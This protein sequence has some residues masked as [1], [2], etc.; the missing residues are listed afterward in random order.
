MT[1]VVIVGGG[2]VGL[3]TALCLRRE[4]L[5]V[6]VVDA[7]RPPLD[8]ACGEGLMPDGVARLARL[9]VSLEGVRSRPFRG[10]R[11]VDGDLAVEADFP[12]SPGRGVRRTVLHEALAV[13]AEEAG[14]EL[15]WGTRVTGLTDAGVTTEEGEVP[16]RWVVGADGLL[17]RVR[18]WAGLDSGERRRLGD[19]ARPPRDRR[20]FGV[21]R[22]YR[23]AP[24][25][26]RVE[27][28]WGD[29]CEA[30]V[31]PVAAD[32]VGVA[33]LWSGGPSDFDGLL[34][35]FPALGARL[36]GAEP[37]SRDRGAG[38]LDQRVRGLVRGRVVLVGDAA[39]YRDA[40][41]GEGLSL[42][43]HQAELLAPA[44]AAGRPR[45]YERCARRAARV[46]FALIAAL[47]WAERRPRLRRR[48]V[49]TLAADPA[50]FARLLAV[51]VGETPL[52]SVGLGGALHL[53]RGL[54]AG[55]A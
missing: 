24:W 46:P 37:C 9:G 3:V 36:T 13:A 15:S 41:T 39:G 14:V 28:H 51:H 31:T 16:G 11:Y 27:V 4:G 40:I 44:L 47:L 52:R 19:G 7:A 29:G 8:K 1:D 50:L 38:P 26:D 49:A 6:R 54:L 30:Y 35:R 10:I 18:S 33:F 25:S 34:A 17:S 32:E 55:T 53:L 42:G 5:T 48:L 21:R 43:F 20:R 23:R 2:P 12:S 22:H 45:A